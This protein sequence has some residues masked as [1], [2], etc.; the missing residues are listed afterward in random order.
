VLAEHYP[1]PL[2]ED[3]PCHRETKEDFDRAVGLFIKKTLDNDKPHDLQY[4]YMQPGGDY[5]LIKELV[6]PP[7]LHAQRFKEM[8]HIAEI[9]PAGDIPKP[10]DALALQWYYMLYHKSD[11]EKFVL[12]GKT[13]KGATVDTVTKF[14]QALYE[15]RKL[16][17]LFDHQEVERLKRRLLR[18]ASED[19]LCKVRNA[20]DDRRTYRAKREIARRDDRR[21]Y[22][23]DRNRDR[24]RYINND[25]DDN[26]RRSSRG[27][28]KR[29]HDE[30]CS[31]RKKNRD[32]NNQPF[33]RKSASAG[34]AKSNGG[35][36]CA[37][38][39]YPDRPAKHAWVDCLENLANQKK[40]VKKEL[41]Y[42]AHDNRRP[43][44]DGPSD[45]DYRTDAASE[46]EDSSRR[47]VSSRRSGDSYDDDNY[48]VSITP[49]S[50]KRAKLKSPARKKRHTI[51]MSDESDDDGN[52][53]STKT[54]KSK[55][56]LD[57]S[58]SD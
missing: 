25:H 5:R 8:L 40:P 29:P 57:L 33:D 31:E 15:Q 7:R 45:D 10:S 51:A 35:T 21:R 9:L 2:D 6:T 39:S 46:S 50:P 49:T 55:D 1:E 4:I 58:D 26:G 23:G 24:R 52:D 41:A 37:L 34:R 16:D 11:R 27:T 3:S 28:S 22:D 48:A 14:F 20:A 44:R 56:P 12:G 32:R 13:L 18:K 47:S 42:Y 19:V 30:R 38:H 36:P 43:A 53:G 54:G 17:G